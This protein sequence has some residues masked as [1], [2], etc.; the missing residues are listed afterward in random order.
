[1]TCG[2]RNDH[3]HKQGLCSNGGH[4]NWLEYYDVTHQTEWFQD[5]VERTGLTEDEFT[6]LFMDNSFKQFTFEKDANFREFNGDEHSV[7]ETLS[8][9]YNHQTPEKSL[10]KM[11][12]EKMRDF[13]LELF[14]K[15]HLTDYL[16]LKR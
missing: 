14:N 1:M 11:S 10:N 13:I 4:D 5:M 9:I 16:G 12:H 6:R 15:G 3:K 8:M 7:G 2:K